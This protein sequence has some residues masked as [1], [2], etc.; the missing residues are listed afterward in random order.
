MTDSS[1]G[2]VWA[3]TQH[4]VR[5]NAELAIP[6]A[7]AF[8]FL[9]QL[10]LQIATGNTPPDQWFSGSRST[11]IIATLL[12]VAAVSLVGQ[13]VLTHI[14]LRGGTGGERTLGGV[15]ADSGGQ[16]L[17][18]L[19]ANLIQGIMVGF[20]LLLLILPGLWLLA[21]FLLVVPIIASGMRDPIEALKQSWKMTANSGFRIMGMVL[22]LIL[23]FLLLSIALSGL[24]AAVGVITTVASGQAADGWGIGRWLFELLSAAVSAAIS[25]YW[26]TFVAMLFTAL[27][28]EKAD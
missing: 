4:S 20:G 28:L 23:G 1:F 11:A 24:G 2:A 25:L 17:P 19:A 6:V 9:P 26:V 7:A 21:R 27:R 14:A 10:A 18:A 15:I 22:V 16:A 13:L 3:A 5:R 12:I 8:L